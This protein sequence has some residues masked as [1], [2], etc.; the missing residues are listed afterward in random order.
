M[1]T[2][3][4]GKYASVLSFKTDQKIDGVI[5]TSYKNKDG[6]ISIIVVNNLKDAL[7][8]DVSL[9]NES[10]KQHL[11]LYQVTENLLKASNFKLNPAKIFKNSD[12]LKAIKILPESITV[13]TTNGLM[14]KNVEVIE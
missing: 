2:R 12:K 11:F 10:K 3:F 8:V 1:I 13:L 14:Q 5:L 9:E 6:N 4:M 7:L